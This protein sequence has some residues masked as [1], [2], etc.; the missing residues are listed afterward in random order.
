MTGF[1]LDPITLI[2]KFVKGVGS[3]TR[4]SRH[5]SRSWVHSRPCWKQSKAS[6]EKRQRRRFSSHIDA[7][8]LRQ[9]MQ[10]RVGWAAADAQCRLVQSRRA[11]ALPQYQVT[12]RRRGY[13]QKG[14]VATP[15]YRRLLVLVDGRGHVS[16]TPSIP[17]F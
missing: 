4:P 3:A 11:V 7:I 8:M 12:A 16:P 2:C 6:R 9:E 1:S 15:I 17:Q 5:S 13:D 14:R 10:R